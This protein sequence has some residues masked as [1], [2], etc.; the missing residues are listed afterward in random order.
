MKL[1]VHFGRLKW[2]VV[3]VL[4][5]LLLAV[6]CMPD[7]ASIRDHT[8][9]AEDL[10][11]LNAI[12]KAIAA[13]GLDTVHPTGPLSLE[14][15]V[16]AGKI[17]PDMLVSRETGEPIKYYPFPD[18]TDSDRI[19]LAS[20]GK[21]GWNIVRCSGS[22]MWVDDG[23]P[24]AAEP[25]NLQLAD[26]RKQEKT[27]SF[28][29]EVKM[30]ENDRKTVHEACGAGR[31]FPAR[32]AELQKM[33]NGFIDEAE[34]G[35]LKGRIVGA[36]S[37]HAG[38]IYS[39]RISGYV[40]KAIKKQADEGKG[41]D[42]VV[43]LGFSHSGGFP[44]AVIM[45]GDA[46]STP[47][48]EAVLDRDAARILMANRNL[49]RF[50][51]GPHQGEHSAENQVPFVQAALPKARL[52]VVLI[53]DH[54]PKTLEQL[55]AGLN[56]LAGQ[57]KILVVASSDMLHDPDYDLVTRTDRATLK[58]IEAMDD[59]KLLQEWSPARQIFCGMMPVVVTMRFT[60]AQK[61]AQGTVLKYENS[62]D[63]HP[64]GR[65]Q[66]VVGYGAVVFLIPEK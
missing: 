44:G 7:F 42:T 53:G 20:R 9:R 46:I 59:K 12:Y 1:K 11:N 49:I 15:L 10:S 22:G 56:D 58:I 27:E 37:P 65:G 66:W 45:D 50:D 28:A 19:L 31:W 30:N 43:V 16:K 60:A 29:A 17:S 63:R 34:V 33:V 21:T 48:G 13:W 18:T 36:I 54:N 52:V 57:K 5:V 26:L 41:P 24:E 61:C 38:Y 23:I 14:Q 3:V 62:G 2:V 55:V 6:L 47:L 32:K 25:P 64:E 51:Y 8:R 40:F 39:G 35:A 4:F